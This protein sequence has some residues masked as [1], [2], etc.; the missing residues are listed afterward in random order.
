MIVPIYISESSPAHIRGKLVT[1]FQLMITFGLVAANI[2]A[3]AFSYVDP[4]NIGW[5]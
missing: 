1:S 4:V 2:I 5:R 3:G